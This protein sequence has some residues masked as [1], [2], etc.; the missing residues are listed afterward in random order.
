M[1]YRYTKLDVASALIG[2][3]RAAGVPVAGGVGSYQLR[4]VDSTGSLALF[5]QIN[6]QGG[7]RRLVAG[8]TAK[9]RREACL[10]MQ[11]Y[12]EGIEAARA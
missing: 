11:A 2:L 4:A 12:R 8:Y 6:E 5:E 9:T 10:M 3:C 1:G 7:V